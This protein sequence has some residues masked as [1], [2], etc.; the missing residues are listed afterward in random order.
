M[1]VLFYRYNNGLIIG[2]SF[3]GVTPLARKF[4]SG[5]IRFGATVHEEGLVVA[6]GF[7][8]IFLRKAK[9][10]IIKCPRCKGKFFSLF[11]ECPDNPGMTMPLIHCAVSG[12]KIII[13]FSFY[14]PDVHALPPAQYDR[15]WMI[16][17]RTIFVLQ[18]NG[19]AA[20]SYRIR[21]KNLIS[22]ILNDKDSYCPSHE[23]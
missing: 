16:I 3:P 12:K 5:F 6:K 22:M 20:I 11:D 21:H 4:D 8:N 17:M 7:A 23:L 10:V 13:P 19:I 15:K 1:K 14:I 9:F 2:N 18:Q